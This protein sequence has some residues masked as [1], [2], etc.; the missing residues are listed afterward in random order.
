MKRLLILMLIFGGSFIAVS[1]L[2]SCKHEPSSLS[3]LP[4][5]CF[6]RDVKLILVSSCSKCHSSGNR[7]GENFDVSSYSS[8]VKA[9]S[10][11]NPWG[12]KLYTIISSPNNPNMMPPKGYP[13][14]S[15][16]DRTKIELWI[17]QGARDTQCDST[18]VQSLSKKN[19]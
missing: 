10:P 9:V 17:L 16:T 19:N 7:E 2:P 13:P 3:G 14:I 5:V 6:E 15:Q 4:T 8:I 1:Y 18:I 12:S 11:G